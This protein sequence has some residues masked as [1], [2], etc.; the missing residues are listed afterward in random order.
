MKTSARMFLGFAAFGLVAGGLYASLTKEYAGLF[1]LSV[2][3]VSNVFLAYLCVAAGDPEETKRRAREEGREE[4]HDVHLPPPSIWPFVIAVGAAITGWGFLLKPPIVI[5][6][7]LIVLM[8][9]AGWAGG[10]DS[11]NRDIAA[12]GEVWRYRQYKNLAEIEEELVR[13]EA[14]RDGHRS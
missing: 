4:H 6:G 3:A 9:V 11:I 5:A 2:F 12:W 10:F 13:L 8:G 14:D 7:A 1:L